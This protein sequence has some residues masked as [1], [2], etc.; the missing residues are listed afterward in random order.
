MSLR[1]L[2]KINTFRASL[3]VIIYLAYSYAGTTSEFL[4]RYALNSLTNK[5]LS[6]FIYWCIAEILIAIVSSLFLAYGT[7]L[8]NKQ[9]QQYIHVI[10]DK[11]IHHY[12]QNNNAKVAEI[13]N[14]L[15]NNM[16]TL[17]DE[18]AKPWIIILSSTLMII[19]SSGLLLSMNWTL[20]VAVVITCF[21][22]ILLPRL[23]QKYT[24]KATKIASKK[25]AVFLNTLADWFSGL[26]VL[27]RYH[28]INRLQN[29]LNQSSDTLADANE[30][31]QKALSTADGLNGLGNSIGQVGIILW[32]G[33]LFFHHQLDL[34]GWLV[35]SNFAGSIFD[36]LW[37]IIEA[38]T[39][40]KATK[41]LRNEI[42]AL[43]QNNTSTNEKT[44][45]PTAISVH[46]L[47]VTYGQHR[48]SF[49]DFTIKT[50]DKVL[51]SGD[52]GTGKSTLL[53]AILGK[54]ETTGGSIEYYNEKGELITPNYRQIG[55]VAQDGVLFPDTIANNVTMF[56]H[57]PET[58]LN[59]VIDLVELT[60]DLS[61]FPQGV[62]TPINL[63]NLNLSG[64]QQ[65]KVILARAKLKGQN[66]LLL[67]EPTSAIDS[68]TSAKIIKSLLASEQTIIMIGH[69]LRP[70]VQKLFD[71]R[72]NLNR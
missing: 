55:Y 31:K 71:Y 41:H 26:S 67:D 36:E 9:T 30:K 13:Q 56:Q 27:R 42:S 60:D 68:K 35:A 3:L 64:G 25:N 32:G 72:I 21:I 1:S 16:K 22:V 17:T 62:N 8:F 47:V 7:Y 63:D 58:Q 37:E 54:L 57:Y 19:M 65:Q 14:V 6:N 53:K 45:S 49:P 66:L 69:N 5:S 28:A 61:K 2:F 4:F 12:Y 39:E 50:H 10:R 33:L 51:L 15:N 34:G 52:S 59:K 48:I 46:A 24:A 38:A 18:Y 44:D 29:V 11:I 20:V 40:I 23:T 43:I 70:E